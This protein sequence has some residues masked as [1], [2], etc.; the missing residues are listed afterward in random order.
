[1]KGTSLRSAIRTLLA[2][3]A[4][5]TVSH[6]LSA[7]AQAQEPPPPPEPPEVV[8]GTTGELEEVVVEGRQRSAAEDVIEERLTQDVVVDVV[9]SEQI[10]R[11]GDSTV[12]LA[13]RRLPAVTLVGDQFI[14]IRGLGERYS[15]TTLNG[16][17][18]PSPDLTRNVIPLDLFPAEIVESLSIQKGYSPEQA[19]AFGGGS[20][21][22][23]T[24]AIPD[25]LVLNVQVGTGWNSDSSDDGLTYPG[26]DDDR[27][28]T[29]DGTRALPQEIR[30][31][32]SDFQ[33]DLSPTGIF[34]ALTRD[35]EFHTLAE[36]EQIN[37]E[38]A[39]SLNRDVDFEQTSL[40]PDLSLEGAMGNAWTLGESG[41]WQVG[42]LALADYKNQWRN[43]ERINRS[44]TF[45]DTDVDHTQR[46]TNQVTLTGSLAV[47][48][49]Y[50]EEHQVQ[51][52]ALYLR[53]T[54]DDASLTLGNNFNFQQDTGDQLRNYRIRYEERDLEVL[55]FHGRHTLGP[56][57]LALVDG[58]MDLSFFEGLNVGWY[59]SDATAKTDIPNEL[60]FS[61]IDEVDP[62]TGEVQST[63]IR[64]SASSAEF[65]FTNL[66]DTATS[67]GFRAGM[68]F[69]VGRFQIE[70]S[71]GYDYSEKGRSYLQT[72]LGLGTTTSAADLTGTPGQVFTDEHILDPENGY[73]MSLGGIGTESYLAAE[74]VDA[75]WG[76]LDTTWNDTW[77][78]S[79]GARWEDF[80][81]L[82]VPIDQYEFDPAI[83][84]IPI[85]AEDLDTLATN[86]DDYYP[87]VAVT[88]MRNDFWA[89][90]FQ[91]RFGWSETTARPDL[92]EISAA[93]YIDPLTEARVS[94]N[95]DLVP[96]DL[97]N[98]DL[99]AEWFFDEGDNF[100]VSL[101]YKDIETPIETIEDAGSDDNISLSFIN[102][103]S[104]EIYGVEFEW[105]KGLEFLAPQSAW[106]D[107][108]FVSGNVT[109]SE[110][111]I[112]IG[113]AAL[114][115]TNNVR[116]MSQ[117]SPWVVNL[118]VGFDAPNQRHSAS[119]AY[120]AFGERLFF[121][122]SNGAPDAFEQPFNSL[123]LI[124]SYYPT[125]AMTIKLR[126]QNLLDEQLEI[127]QG[128]VTV[129]EQTVGSVVKLDLSYRF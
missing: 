123:D 120:S 85:P 113:N 40:D 32:I 73:I 46:T 21:D 16:A 25:Q 2:L 9:N 129:L 36:A 41:D 64:P 108:F 52:T 71:G 23:R 114:N 87:A 67:Y 126:L 91:L 19:A 18:V 84:K 60:L 76:K 30:T 37:R 124:Y 7:F 35:G 79:A 86:E 8:E 93:T 105:L 97:A 78:L 10:S 89:E 34:E 82:S 69:T 53:N 74:T 29:D 26:G 72:Q 6:G 110:S 104:A 83:G 121:A 125:D 117:H 3:S 45:P 75:V 14:Y 66:E 62:E 1:M 65:R 44:V 68:P 50:T 128:G 118:Q 103:E 115:L 43:R 70:P 49:N 24:R 59:Y 22:I 102:A 51:A 107:A 122:G 5:A 42:T 77:R 109:L 99:R 4:A 38:L 119:L 95:P 13:L 15:S 106:A 63:S 31:A 48:L 100:T 101:F 92:R 39:T 127:E 61:A 55:Q 11:V 98:F 81:Q 58:L 96:A 28:G 57:T 33:G 116:E 112:T 80:S 27:W 54:E 94:G 12:S 20:V 90:R 111:E 56:D 47:G 17:Y 88:W